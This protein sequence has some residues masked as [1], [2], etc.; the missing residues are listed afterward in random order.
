LV[1]WVFYFNPKDKRILPPKRI[2]QFGWTVE[3][4]NPVSVIG[5]VG[6]YWT[7]FIVTKIWW[8]KNTLITVPAAIVLL[9]CPRP[10][11]MNGTR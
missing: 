8:D 7:A 5:I 1:P 2:P 9:V 11:K 3:F 6:N 10:I 4:A